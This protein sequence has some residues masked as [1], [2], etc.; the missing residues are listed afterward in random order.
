MAAAVMGATAL[1]LIPVGLLTTK[2]FELDHTTGQI[3]RPGSPVPLIRNVTVFALQYTI[4]VIAA[5]DPDGRTVATL[6]GRA[7]SG[8]TTGYFL[9]RTIALLRRSWKRQRSD[10]TM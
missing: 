10:V 9:G 7:I 8:A 6:I 5:V 3:I 4:A 1:A 2:P